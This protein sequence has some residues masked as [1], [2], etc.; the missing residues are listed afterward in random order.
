MSNGRLMLLD[1]HSL[2]YR[3]YFALPVENFSTTTGQPTN[4]VYGFTSMLINILRDE[5]PTHVAVAFDISRKTFRSEMFP[6]YKANRESS[7]EPFRGQVPLIQEVL[8]AM[9]IKVI[10]ADG[11]EADDVIATL[12]HQAKASEFDVVIVTGDRDSF[13]LVDEHTTVLYPRKGMSDLARMTPEAVE[14]KYGLTPEQ[15]P[16]FAA[17]RGD[18]SDNL[19][20]IPG[21]GEKTA[22]KWIVEYGSLAA[23]VDNAD[24]ISGKV[25]ESLRANL[26][27]VLLNRQ[28]T[29]L[30]SDVPMALHVDDC[31]MQKFDAQAIDQLFTTLQ[32]RALRERL[33]ALQPD[34]DATHAPAPVELK[35]VQDVSAEH[36]PKWLDTLV[37]PVCFAFDGSWGHGGGE[38][39]AV[40]VQGSGQPAAVLDLEDKDVRSALLAWFADPAVHLLPRR[41]LHLDLPR[42]RPRVAAHHHRTPQWHDVQHLAPGNHRHRRQ[43]GFGASHRDPEQ[44]EWC[45]DGNVCV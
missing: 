33:A 37:Q 38:L 23:L 3:A 7:P 25:G 22:T 41:W 28:L 16:D 29:Q 19:P 6:E 35:P 11:Y 10:E 44:G 34:S 8:H 20:G 32:F 18:P 31:A 36:L 4:A 9:G 40:A 17:L 13:Q 2:A 27:Q 43:P 21:V 14:E 1:G 30:D 24:K 39:R 26:A 15:Y 42:S 45:Q 12:S 5:Q